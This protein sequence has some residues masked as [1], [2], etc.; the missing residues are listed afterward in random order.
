MLQGK[1]FL[2]QVLL[3]SKLILAIIILLIILTFAWKSYSAE[4]NAVYDPHYPFTIYA[5][6]ILEGGKN[7]TPKSN[8]TTQSPRSK[9][10]TGKS[11][12]YGNK[13][14]PNRL[15]RN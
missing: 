1:R 7:A 12:P 13:R 3:E 5:L 6:T 15:P 2:I 10:K 11:N 8:F 9:S 14:N 4:H